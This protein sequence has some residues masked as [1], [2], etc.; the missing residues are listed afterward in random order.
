[1]QLA[2]EPILIGE[3]LVDPRDDS[4]TRGSERVKLEPRTMR[5]LMRL[6]QTPGEVVSQDE[7]LESVWTGVVVGTASVYQSMSQLRKVL[8]DT[9]DPPRYIETVARKGYRLVAKVSASP[10]S[11]AVEITE[12]TRVAPVPADAPAP[13]R[14]RWW[15][16]LASLAVVAVM[17][18]SFWL[19]VREQTPPTIAVLPFTDLT[20]GKTEQAFCDGLTEEVSN[21]LAQLPTLRVVARTSAF[22][23]RDRGADVRAIG[24]ELQTTHVLEGSLRRSGNQVRITVQLVDTRNGFQ[25]W[26]ESYDK[27]ANDVLEVQED[28]ARKVADNLELRI[29]A[30]TDMRF[31][32]RRSNSAE[33]QR[34]YLL[35]KAHVARQ[36]GESTARAIELYREALKAD[37]DFALAKVWL[38]HSIMSQRYFSEK[39]IEELLPQIQPLLADV[40]RTSPDLVDLYV[41]RG[42]LYT[43][44]R[45]LEPAMQDLRHALDLNPNSAYAASRLGY[46]FLTLGQPRD[47]LTYFTMAT[48]LDPRAYSNHGYKCRAFS[49]LAAYEMAESACERART[50]N[51]ESS[52]VYSVA[53][54]LAE[55]RGDIEKA[56]EWSDAALKHGSS[57]AAMQSERARWLVNLGMLVDAGSVYRR[58]VAENPEAV[59]RSAGL[60]FAGSVAAID[61]G[62]AAGLRKFVDENA[63]AGTKD[64]DTLLDLANAALMANDPAAAK[65]YMDRGLAAP[66]MTS[67]GLASAWGAIDGHSH[68]LVIAATL[69]A[70][71]DDTGANQRLDEL[72]ALLDRLEAAGVQTHGFYGLKAEYAALRGQDDEAIASLRR[73]VQL[74]WYAAW[75]AEHQPYF[76]ALRSRAEYREL[77]AAV[78]ARNAV[79][80]ANLRPRL[81][82]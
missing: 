28:I 23:Y 53:A 66:D 20:E 36:D 42:Q 9:D 38:A 22:Q 6:A 5:L 47:A 1:M 62:G 68:L 31:A 70:N 4:V 61:A 82:R 24:Q 58:A 44:L 7:L 79:T 16:A 71:G 14:G 54:Q 69:R 8:G 49:D 45:Q 26:S 3:W 48:S 41:V 50:L 51:P 67:D 76:Q 75:L 27:K 12:A 11:H 10:K 37:P 73:A 64:P 29:T 74:G 30:E 77:I 35:A 81:L 65:V 25:V 56:V 40:E 19:F 18:F 34:L 39:P 72:G 32:G 63:L 46:Y 57:I 17:V 55:A 59:R 2:N 15:I 60:S 80:A 33:A 78:N 13:G 43:E 52:W 21:W